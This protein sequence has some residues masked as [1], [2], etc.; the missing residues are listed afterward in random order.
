[1]E[2]GPD[3]ELHAAEVDALP[4]RVGLVGVP[5]TVLAPG[6]RRLL[7]GRRRR[8]RLAT[9]AAKAEHCSHSPDLLS[10]WPHPATSGGGAAGP[11]PPGLPAR[12]AEAVLASCRARQALHLME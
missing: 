7:D 12:R 1:L 8:L 2:P 9:A 3:G 6:L 11:R 4:L 5:G 10:S